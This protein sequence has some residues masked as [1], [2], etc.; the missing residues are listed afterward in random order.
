MNDEERTERIKQRLR[1]A[2]PAFVHRRDVATKKL[3]ELRD[4]GS[5]AIQGD[6]PFDVVG[7]YESQRKQ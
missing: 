5:P 3:N 1:D 4:A 6:D 2:I 7:W